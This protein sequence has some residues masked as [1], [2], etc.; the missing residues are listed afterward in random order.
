MA[1]ESCDC[2]ER[3]TAGGVPKSP[4]ADEAATSAAIVAETAKGGRC[5]PHEAYFLFFLLFSPLLFI[6]VV[7]AQGS[8]RAAEVDRI[9]RRPR[10]KAN[11]EG[12]AG[13]S[14]AATAVR[15]CW[16]ILTV[17]VDGVGGRGD[18]GGEVT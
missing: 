14:R 16:L 12:R 5:L 1:V 17:V 11:G 2:V 15:R 10:D 8:P 4:T 18:E 13:G 7:P 3:K 6:I 9:G